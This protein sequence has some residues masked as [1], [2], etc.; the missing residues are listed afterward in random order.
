MRREAAR[1]VWAAVARLPENNRLALLMYYIRGD[2]YR[3]IAEFLGVPETTVVGR[4][5]RA[6]GQLRSLLE[7]RR[8]E[9]YLADFGD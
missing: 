2:S 1:E 9:E 7:E 5:H 6:R 4:L 3:E 8:I